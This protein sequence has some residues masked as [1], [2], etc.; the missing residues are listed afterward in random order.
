ML[1][2]HLLFSNKRDVES[3]LN[4]LRVYIF[5][6]D[7]ISKYDPNQ[8]YQKGDKCYIVDADGKIKFLSCIK[9]TT[10]PFDSSCWEIYTLVD[11]LSDD[12]SK[13]IIV[14]TYQPTEEVNKL[15]IQPIKYGDYILPEP[16]PEYEGD[17]Y[18]LLFTGEIPVVE[19]IDTG[20]TNSLDTGDIIIDLEGE[21]EAATDAIL[22][23]FKDS[24]M[25]I[26]DEQEDVSVS[27]DKPGSSDPYFVWFDIDPSDG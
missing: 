23:Q 12:L 26:V 13:L 1:N 20:L 4:L 27:D 25:Y 8:S 9:E 15:W 24:G 2:A 16:I 11:K 19:E 7:G 22:E 10:G 21:Y 18:T 5:G 14:S 17:K 6:E 3:I